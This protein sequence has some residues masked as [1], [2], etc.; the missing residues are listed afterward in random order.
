MTKICTKCKEQKSK[1]EY[2][3]RKTSKDGYRSQ[4]K[5]CVKT[6]SKDY[7]SVINYKY[8]KVKCPTCD[9]LKHVQSK[10]CNICSN[11]VNAVDWKNM[12]IGEKTYDNQKYAKYSYIRYYARV[13]AKELEWE[14]CKYCGYDRH[15]EVAH[16][17]PISSY[18]PD[19]TLGVINDPSNL[20]PLCPNCH[21]ECDNG[22]RDIS[23]GRL[24]N[25]PTT[26]RT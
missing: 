18:S 25:T 24:I 9:D 16:I 6:Q 23:D 14:C 1:A 17:K 21:Y 10:H 4:C 8:K 13:I 26:I 19:T 12:T 2:S 15:F 11:K 20:I 7:P 22:L 5:D 3:K